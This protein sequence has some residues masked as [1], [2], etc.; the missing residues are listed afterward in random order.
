[1]VKLVSRAVFIWLILVTECHHS[2][3]KAQS[4]LQFVSALDKRPHS[5]PKAGMGPLGGASVV[6]SQSPEAV[7]LSHGA[8]TDREGQA[9]RPPPSCRMPSTCI[10][11]IS[12]CSACCLRAA[13]SPILSLLRF[14]DLGSGGASAGRRNEGAPV[15]NLSNLIRKLS[16]PRGSGR[17]GLRRLV[18]FELSIM[19]NVAPCK[20]DTHPS[21]RS[22][23]A[24]RGAA[25]SWCVLMPLSPLH[26][27]LRPLPPIPPDG[28]PS[29]LGHPHPP[30]TPPSPLRWIF[31]SLRALVSPLFYPSF[32]FSFCVP[33][34]SLEEVHAS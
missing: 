31:P 4:A 23:G 29:P 30:T 24:L 6:S 25:N 2:E 14:F 28:T 22:S 5:P 8:S 18:Y 10:R 32:S 3:N 13:G 16:R 27:K 21:I 26:R 12:A 20:P 11:E 9:T 17:H 33:F 7:D 34:Q 15:T 19:Q 1:M